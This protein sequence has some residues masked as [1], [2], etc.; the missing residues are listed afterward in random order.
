M[1]SIII[2]LASVAAVAPAHAEIQAWDVI[3]LMARLDE[4]GGPAGWVDLQLRRR[5]GST[6][7]LARPALGWAFSPT[8]FAHVGYAWIP[9]APDD[10][11]YSSEHRVWQQALFNGTARPDLKYQVRARVEQRF[12]PGSG[13]GLRLRGLGRVQWQ[14][15]DRVPLQ[16]VVWDELFVGLNET[17]DFA[18]QGFDQNRAFA[19]VGVDT[20]IK[21][22][23]VEAGYLHLLTQAGDRTDHV[24]GFFVTANTWLRAAPGL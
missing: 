5:G 12:G 20:A 24:L 11:T 13:V 2:L 16:L 14:P 6:Q 4:S 15:S 19:G 8:L 9:T 10:G 22:L 3:T 17:T 21:G 1:K 18:L 23:R 7:Y